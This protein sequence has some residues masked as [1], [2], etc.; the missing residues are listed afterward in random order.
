MIAFV[1]SSLMIVNPGK[2]LLGTLR[3]QNFLFSQY[4]LALA[5]PKRN[6]CLSLHQKKRIKDKIIHEGNSN[7]NF[8]N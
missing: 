4:F 2:K 6:T 3:L 1:F 8:C 5:V 7:T